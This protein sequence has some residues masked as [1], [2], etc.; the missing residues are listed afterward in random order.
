MPFNST[1]TIQNCMNSTRIKCRLA[2]G[3]AT[4]F[5]YVL[6]SAPVKRH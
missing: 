6:Y 4:D 1:H 2:R 3:K 5:P